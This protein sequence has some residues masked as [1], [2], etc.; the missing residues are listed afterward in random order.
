[1][2][3]EKEPNFENSLEELDKMVRKLESG[4]LPLDEAIRVFEEGTRLRKYCEDK[5]KETER[6]IDQIIKEK[7]PAKKGEKPATRSMTEPGSDRN[8]VPEDE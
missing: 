3:K 4:D 6:R 7:L 5:L 1:M 2:A 8:S